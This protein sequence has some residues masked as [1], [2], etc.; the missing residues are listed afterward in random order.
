MLVQKYRGIFI[1]NLSGVDIVIQSYSEHGALIDCNRWSQL[2]S[3]EIALKTSS[4]VS[5]NSDR[6]IQRR[7]TARKKS[8]R[9]ITPI[10]I[11]GSLFKLP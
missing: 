2:V 4:L 5:Q 8:T 6:I 1:L 11:P 10:Q 9:P 7:E 3:T